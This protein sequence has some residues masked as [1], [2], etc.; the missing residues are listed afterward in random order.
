MC[1]HSGMLWTEY[2]TSK[3]NI[4]HI[5]QT[6]KVCH[7]IKLF[8]THR[9]LCC[10]S[11]SAAGDTI[12]AKNNQIFL[13]FYE[14]S[15]THICGGRECGGRGQLPK[16]S[17]FWANRVCT[18]NFCW[19]NHVCTKIFSHS[20]KL[21]DTHGLV[22]CGSDCGRWRLPM[23]GSGRDCGDSPRVNIDHIPLNTP[24]SPH[25][26]EYQKNQTIK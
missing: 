10:S 11:E 16:E 4:A 26:P 7:S 8:D 3:A 24:L 20:I 19:A 17:A 13:P 14:S 22:C 15:L 23:C 1:V 6:P 2:R 25:L 5:P 21:F 9:L 18:K 12:W